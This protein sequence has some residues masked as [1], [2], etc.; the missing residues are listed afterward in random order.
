MFDSADEADQSPFSEPP[1]PAGQ[2]GPLIEAEVGPFPVGA[3]RLSVTLDD[4]GPN[5]VTIFNCIKIVDPE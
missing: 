5:P 1:L 4:G 3:Y 2:V